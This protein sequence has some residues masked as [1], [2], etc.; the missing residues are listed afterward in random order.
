MIAEEGRPQDGG[1]YPE[2]SSRVQAVVSDSGPIDLLY[3]EE[4]GTLRSV[5][6]RFLGGPM[7]IW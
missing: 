1:P 3:Q 2:E 7:A 6:R 5:I 4:R